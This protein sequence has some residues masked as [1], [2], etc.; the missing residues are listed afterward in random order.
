ML[1]PATQHLP[2]KK[3]SATLAHFVNVTKQSYQFQAPHVVAQSLM[4]IGL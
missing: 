3:K 2:D 4:V 1:L